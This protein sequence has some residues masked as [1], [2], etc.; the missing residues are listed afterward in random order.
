MD[1]KDE[2]K[3]RLSVDEVIGDYLELKK[4]GRN[5]KALSPFTQ[6]KTASLMVS[7]E[8]QIW[9]DFSSNQGGDIFT[10]IMMVEGVDFREA[11]DILARK[12]GVDMSKYQRA[13]SAGHSK[14]KARVYEAL[15]LAAKYYHATLV[16]TPKALEYV[17]RKRGYGQQIIK[18]FE[19]GYSANNATAL[20]TFLTKKGFNKK[21]MTDAGI[22]VVRSNQLIDMFRGRMMVPLADG[23]GRV[24]GFTARV[25]DTSLPKYINTPQTIVYDKSRHVFGLHLA[26]EAIREQD[27]VVVVEG[28]LDVIASHKTKVRNIVATAGTAMTKDHFAQIGRLTRDVRLAFDQ[29]RAGLEATERAIPLAQTAGVRLSIIT[30]T[31]GK[32]PDEL[33]SQSPE[34]WEKT[35]QKSEYVMDWLIERY[36][37]E[38]DITSAEGK[39]TFTDRVLA[40]LARI[41]DP[42][43]QEHYVALVASLV[44]VSKETIFKKIQQL[45]DGTA[46]TKRY[47][48]IK[49]TDLPKTNENETV[50]S[51]FQDLLLGLNCVH[52][53]VQHSIKHIQP[54]F[55]TGKHR[56][57]LMQYIIDYPEKPLQTIPPQ[58]KDIEDYVK[59]VLLK[60][61]E[62]YEDWD[63]SDRLIEAIGLARRLV[64]DNQKKVQNVLSKKIKAA[65]IA[66]DEKLRKE[67][68]VQFDKL[69][70]EK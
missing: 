16:K 26:K 36:K 27:F 56:Q 31:G 62:L 13:E 68:L 47:K 64:H 37:K 38:Y 20:T 41:D 5:F 43:E 40:V 35:V 12:A 60:T 69:L 9:H 1:A 22:V 50:Q 57:K 58:L 52:P 49:N 63:S 25:L 11:L 21:E 7:P 65:E 19:L 28:N 46:K 34:A 48:Q 14:H 39:R 59:I 3:Q 24:I 67:L 4:S 55:F 8:K 61:E 66:G 53:D 29:D 23:Q 17:V 70:K 33:I 18:D 15:A 54:E 42:V 2:V 45:K 51:A 32:D 44:H 10:F 6:E 30:I